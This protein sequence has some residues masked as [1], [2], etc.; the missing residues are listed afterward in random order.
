MPITPP[1]VTGAI[2]LAAPDLKGPDWLRLATIV[3]TSVA[4]WAQLPANLALQ[5]VTTGAAGTGTVFGKMFVAP[6]PLPVNIAMPAFGFLGINGQQ[7]ARAVGMGVSTAFNTSGAYVGAS[8]G[9]A[10]GTDISKVTVSNGA[11]LVS[12]MAATAAST[13]FLGADMP[14]L[15]G[16]LGTGISIMMFTGAG[17]GVVTGPPAPSPAAGT[18]F[19]K[20]V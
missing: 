4:I 17:V 6:V 9:V 20:V 8:A 7:V 10:A 11:T 14:R 19:S 3:G 13:G 18:S 1:T 16:A 12:I 15:A 5:G 2:L